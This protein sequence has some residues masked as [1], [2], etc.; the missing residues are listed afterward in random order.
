M[1]YRA[2]HIIMPWKKV[3]MHIKNLHFDYCN[4]MYACKVGRILN[5]RD[6][7]IIGWRK[8]IA[9][10]YFKNA[11]FWETKPHTKKLVF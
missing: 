10:D 8:T 11:F 4:K 6:N 3:H 9:T 1:Q 2:S 7:L 5:F